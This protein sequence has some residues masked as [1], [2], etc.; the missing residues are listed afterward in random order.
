M[1]SIEIVYGNAM[2]K[3][4]FAIAAIMTLTN[5]AC[6]D[7][8]SFPFTVKIVGS[9]EAS[10]NGTLDHKT[11]EIGIRFE[12]NNIASFMDGFLTAKGVEMDII[13][14][15]FASNDA[16]IA[17]YEAYEVD[18][19]LPN[20]DGMGLKAHGTCALAG[21]KSDKSF[22]VDCNVQ[23]ESSLYPPYKKAEISFHWVSTGMLQRN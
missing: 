23:T 14:T 2:S 8:V 21:P 10:I 19:A 6:A 11:S 18:V 20:G 1:E 3:Y 15:R 17:S 12:A 5:A 22:A 9:G 13:R 7:N 16:G 4:A